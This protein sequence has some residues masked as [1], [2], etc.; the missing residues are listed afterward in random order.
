MNPQAEGVGHGH[1]GRVGGAHRWG[2]AARGGGGIQTQFGYPL[3]LCTPPFTCKR[4]RKGG[5]G[6][7]RER[8]GG[9]TMGPTDICRRVVYV[10]FFFVFIYVYLLSYGNYRWKNQKK[11][12]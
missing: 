10:L 4:A 11:T 1:R 9:G 2:H 3:P 12:D 7:G 8:R 5:S 6:A